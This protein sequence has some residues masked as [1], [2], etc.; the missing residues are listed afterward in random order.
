M[1]AAGALSVVVVVLAAVVAGRV[2]A[3]GVVVVVSVVVAVV[4]VVVVVV[5]GVVGVAVG[6]ARSTAVG[7]NQ[8][9]AGRGKRRHWLWR[10]G[11]GSSGSPSPF[12]TP[13]TAPCRP[14]GL[15]PSRTGASREQEGGEQHP[16]P[17]PAP[18]RRA[19]ATQ[20]LR[21]LRSASRLSASSSWGT[22]GQRQVGSVT[23][24]SRVGCPN[25]SPPSAES[26]PGFPK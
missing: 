4:V 25:P 1:V 14:G 8:V 15:S 2:V 7:G 19:P 18:A 24:M 5:V 22:E 16:A 11:Y 20:Q 17:A 21:R 12:P 13:S 3:A 26:S 10:S 9:A 23:G 6:L